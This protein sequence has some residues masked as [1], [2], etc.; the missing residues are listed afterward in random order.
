M[1]K[2]AVIGVMTVLLAIPLKKDKPE[3]GMLLVLTG[4]LLILGLSFGELG[5]I[6]SWID[7]IKKELGEAELYVG[8][9]VKM[10]GITYVA[11]FGSNLCKDAG[12]AAIAGQIEFFGK[13]LI[14]AVSRP[15]FMT[16]L[17]TIGKI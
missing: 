8:V 16:L 1:I 12:Y 11:E 7:K 17:E 9:L 15:I 2:V 14:L 13:L 6:L 5:E 10:L 3:F 4:C